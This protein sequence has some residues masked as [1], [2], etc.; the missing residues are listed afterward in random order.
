M[1]DLGVFF[2][3]MRGVLD[4]LLDRNHHLALQGG[5]GRVTPLF[6]LTSLKKLIKKAE[7]Q[8]NKDS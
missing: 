3:L 6:S 8:P 1:T 5:W 2:L 4:I 7:T